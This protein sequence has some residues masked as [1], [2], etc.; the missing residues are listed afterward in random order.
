MGLQFFAFFQFSNYLAPKP[1]RFSI[2]NCH[3]PIDGKLGEDTIKVLLFIWHYF[4]LILFITHKPS[5]QLYYKFETTIFSSYIL[6]VPTV[7]ADECSLL[8]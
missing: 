5:K 1:S 6:A 8:G 4:F 2:V 3:A 7:G